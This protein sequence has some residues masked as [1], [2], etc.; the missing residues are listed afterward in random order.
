MSDFDNSHLENSIPFDDGSLFANA[1]SFM[2]LPFNRDISDINID[3]VIM[4]IPYDLATTGRAGTRSA[5]GA[6]RV[7]SANLRWEEKRWPWTFSILKG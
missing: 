7:A 3:A 2:G 5:P 4:G 1:Y 6:I